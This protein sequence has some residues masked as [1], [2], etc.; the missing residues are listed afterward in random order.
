[1]AAR[2]VRTTERPEAVRPALYLSFF[3]STS[4]QL[5]GADLWLEADEE[6]GG[7]R[8]SIFWA[9]QAFPDP[10][11]SITWERLP[12]DVDGGPTSSD[13]DAA[14]SC[15]D[16]GWPPMIDGSVPPEETWPMDPSLSPR[17]LIFASHAT[18]P[19]TILMG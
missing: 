1:M 19:E 6:I 15:P 2:P 11:G 8:D 10:C 5:L 16:S 3:D 14:A 12:G 4:G 9:G 17:R 18:S 7:C 13:A